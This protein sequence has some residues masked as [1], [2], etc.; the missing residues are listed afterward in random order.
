MTS[1]S[2]QYTALN[3]IYSIRVFTTVSTYDVDKAART[4]SILN[5]Q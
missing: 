3:S 5:K 2:P 1:L 4:C